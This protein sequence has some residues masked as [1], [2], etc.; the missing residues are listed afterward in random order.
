[1]AILTEAQIRALNDLGRT[2]PTLRSAFDYTASQG[3]PGTAPPSDGLGD[4][5][6]A[7][8]NDGFYGLNVKQTDDEQSYKGI[9][10]LAF[11]ASSFYLTQNDPNTDEAIVNF[12]G[13][14]GGVTDHGALAGLSDDDHTQ[15]TLV[16][17]TRAFTGDQSVGSN[18]LTNLGSPTAATDAARLQ[19]IG[20]GFYGVIFKESEIGGYD[21]LDD[22]LI[23]DS[24][25]FYLQSDGSDKPLVSIVLSSFPGAAGGEA[26]TA[27]NLGSG[28]GVFS[29]KAGVDLQFK[30]LVAGGGVALSSDST[31]ITIDSTSK[32]YG[33]IFK[34]SEAGGYS[35][36]DDT[37]VVDSNFFYL[38]SDGSGKPLLSLHE[39]NIDHGNLAGLSDDDH[40]QYILA[41]GSR[42]FT[43]DQSMGSNK[44]TGLGAPTADTDAARLQDIGPG[45]YGIVVKDDSTTVITDSIEFTGS[46]FN[47]STSGDGALVAVDASVARLTDLP[48]GFYGVIFKESEAGG[49]IEQDD[50][51]VVDSAFFYLQSD[52]SGKP[53]L[54]LHEENIDHGKLT[55]LGDDDHTQYILADG[56]RA[57]TGDQSIGSN[58]LTNLG[59]PT[60]GTDA[61]RFQDIGPGFYGI[62]V[63]DDSTTVITDSIEFDG[64]DFDVSASGDGALVALDASVAKLVDIG[65]GFYGVIFK[66]SEAGG[67]IEQEDTLVFDS[68]FFYLQSD[69]SEK[70]IVSIV[71]S[72][73]PGA[74]GGEAN[75]AS[76]LGSGEGVFSTKSG[77]DLQFKSL[78]SGGGIALSSDS[79]EITIDSTSKFYG[80]IFRESETGGY[81]EQDDTLVVDSAFFYLQSDGSGKPLLSL[82]EENIDHGNLAGL[83]D[84]D[85]TQYTLVD[86][87]RAFTGDQSMGSNKLTNL[88]APTADT[89]AARLQDIGPGFY[90][91]VVKDDSTTVVTDS[92]EFTGSDFNVSASGDGALVA[93]D[94]SVARLTDLPPGF[95]GVIFKESEAGGYSE[96]DDTLVVDSN[97]FYL[98]SDGSGKPLLSLHEEN[99]D[100]GNLSGLSDDDHTQYILAD[101]TRAFTGDQSMGSNK[102]TNLGAPTADTDAAR[103]QDIGPGFYG[104]IFKESEAGGYIEQDDTLVFDSTFFYLQS[105]NSSKPIVSIVLSSFPGAAGGE[106]NTASNLGSGEGV[107]STKSGVDLRFKSLIPGGGIALSS[108]SDEITIDSTSKFYGVIFKESEAGGYLEQD[109]TLVVDSAFFYLQS[110]GSGKPL[111]S[112]HDEN[113]RPTSLSKTLTVESPTSSEDIDIWFTNIAI[114]IVAVEGVING[115]ASTPSVTCSILHNTDR[116]A[117]GNQAV[118]AQAVT[119]IT[120]GDSLTLGGDTTVPA[121]SFIWLETTGQNGTTPIITLTV[122]YTE[123]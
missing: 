95:Y 103:L 52:G 46:D 5:L 28:E 119:S 92:I 63:K 9:N 75:T 111:L 33:V 70:P 106:A 40:T 12:R 20:P 51:L 73:F 76:N 62:V 43:G 57:F 22:T 44:L 47:V 113:V 60:T 85:H 36:Q 37:L 26:N 23:F 34:E 69:G 11:E 53:L 83:S 8:D 68:T 98:Q 104:V 122:R 99:I 19:D 77:V 18:K 41:D 48:P 112:F 24:T 56:T 89:D 84:D 66:E 30:S 31:E 10:T 115:G 100:H 86:G 61:A 101:G 114:T 78:V 15:Y 71:L 27:S 65:P 50:T 94:A 123:S 102:L 4:R 108:D 82:H 74:G 109:D 121:N 107:F 93:I 29:A 13:S 6:A 87:T 116:S 120:T 90:G 96:Q 49:Y 79:N 55:G 59:A 17:G 1:M 16:D 14:G 72:S 42:A 7:D 25:F 67:Y 97:F 38:Q 32:F 21:E 105:D 58:K 35:E 3:V 2:T 81:A 39:E 110:D 54:S 88:G 45:F 117:A 91:I 64:N 118:N 80:V